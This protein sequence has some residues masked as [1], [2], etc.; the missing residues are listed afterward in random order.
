M[1]TKDWKKT[2]KDEWEYKKG[3]NS[4]NVKKIRIDYLPGKVGLYKY[5]IYAMG[6]YASDTISSFKTKSRALAYVKA[7]M[8]KH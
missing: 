8:S 2:E 7:Y 3:Y 4:D 1:A 5:E 6:K